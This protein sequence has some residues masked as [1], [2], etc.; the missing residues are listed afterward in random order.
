MK[1]ESGVEGGIAIKDE[2]TM[3]VDELRKKES[4]WR[5]RRNDSRR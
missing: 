1:E 3:I 5:S 4:Q 2:E